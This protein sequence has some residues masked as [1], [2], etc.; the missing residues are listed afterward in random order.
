MS[1]RA[2]GRPRSE[3]IRR[4]VLAAATSLVDES[5]Y[6]T[7]TME[8]IARR[9]DVSKQTVYRWWPSPAA[10]LLE[11][12]NDGAARIAPLVE[13]GGLD[14][15]LRIFVRRS[16]LGA[17]GRNA[18]LL[19]ALMSEAQRDESFAESF[20]NGFLAQRRGVMRELLVRARDRGDLAPGV[21]VDV[22][23]E[24]FFGTLWYRLLAASGPVNTRFADK[25]TDALLTV[26]RA[27]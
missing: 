25:L 12:L 3:R 1:V 14:N 19:T 8:A 20:R 13:A 21:D 4:A 9:A 17:R 6:G 10:I 7:A 18:R 26:L 2:P 23:V 5:G 27:E 11:A 15:D 16:V 24:M 22:V